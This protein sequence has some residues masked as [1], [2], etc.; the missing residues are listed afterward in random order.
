MHK[1]SYHTLEETLL[2]HTL[3]NGLR[4]FGIPR[5][6]FSKSF[7]ILATDFGSNDCR[8][9]LEGQTY[10][11]TPGIAH[12]LEHKM[13][14]EEDG[15]ALQK[16]TATGAQPNA[17]TSH[18]MTAFH[19][20]STD[21]FMDNLRILLHFVFTP[22]FTDENVKKEKGI[23][24][25]EIGMLE[26]TPGW[27]TYVGVMQALYA[28]HPT[29][30]SI[31]G[32]CES[33]EPITPDMLSLCHRAF[34]SPKNMVL[35]V[36][37][38]FDFD[39]VIAL[40][41]TLTPTLAAEI[42]R[43]DYGAEPEQAAQPELVHKMAVSRPMFG[44]GFKDEPGEDFYFQQRCGEIAVQ[45]LCG[46]STQ[47]YDALYQQGL[48]DR[49][50]DPD[51]TVFR[52]GACALITGESGDPRAVRQALETELARLARQGVDEALFSR[53]KK[54]WYG[55]LVR[56]TEDPA[57]LCRMQVEACFD[58]GC[59]FDFADALHRMTVED[60]N[61]RLRVWASPGRS[62]MA[63]IEPRD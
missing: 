18:T 41:E 36:C 55:R 9:T 7:A 1:V 30:I 15:N 27:Q 58:G 50:F 54:A 57:Q 46:A 52:G 49:S 13:F 35:V 10:E 26:D 31:A 61:Q 6:Q 17:F 48:I 12:F 22:Y 60:V 24:A 8:F 29:R 63:I 32:S 53:V 56:W 20:T 59:V 47:V 38:E 5:P 34:Y 11:I 39:A 45:C 40:A 62:G 21:H 19:F 51:Y 4:I 37:G 44:L 23:I 16:L 43:R 42:A 25:Q 3:E 14:E 2:T 28:Q 33:I